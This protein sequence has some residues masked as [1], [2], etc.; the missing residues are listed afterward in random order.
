LIFLNL[1]IIIPVHNEEQIIRTTIEKTLRSL[2]N[3]NYSYEILV[4]DDNSNDNTSKIL[5]SIS[6]RNKKV[7]VLRKSSKR[8]GPT[9]LGSAIRY[10]FEHA[11]GDILI[12]LMGDLSDDPKDIPKFL[13]KIK[14]GYDVVCGSR[15]ITGSKIFGYPKVKFFCNRLYNELFSL[16]FG[17]N[18]NDISNAFKAYRREVIDI[19]KPESRGFEITSEIVL[20]AHIHGFKITQVPVSWQGRGLKGK[21]KFGAFRSLSFVIFKLPKI[22]ISYGKLSLILWLSFLLKCIRRV[23]KS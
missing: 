16:L 12:P 20:K 5:N 19:T 23:F 21:S 17:I 15:F 2:K 4:I 13:E 8:L 18:T 7:R 14:E 22:G 1:S 11:S 3:I 10:G 9:G 6:K